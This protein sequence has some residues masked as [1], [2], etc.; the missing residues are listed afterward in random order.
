MLL[1]N[2]N[3]KANVPIAFGW[4]KEE[5]YG[6][7]KN[8]LELI[9][10]NEHGWALCTDFKVVSLLMGLMRGNPKYPCHLCLWDSRWK[11]QYEKKDWPIRTAA[12][13]KIDTFN[14]VADALVPAEKILLPPLHIKLGLV[15]NY[16]KY[17]LRRNADARSFLKTFF[18]NLSNAKLDE[19]KYDLFIRCDEKNKFYLIFIGVLVGPDIRRLVANPDFPLLLDEHELTAFKALKKVIS[20]FL[21]K[22][23]DENYAILVQNMLDAFQ[24]INV[25]MSSKIHYMHCHLD[26]FARQLPTESDEQGERFHQTC[27]PFEANYKGKDV[28]ALITDLC[29][30]L[31]ADV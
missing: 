1:H 21:G 18:P 20:G 28:L 15:K 16:L 12:N 27:K 30:Q 9:K 5:S 6:S 7:I 10:Y 31:A 3:I 14:I 19:G 4:D 24:T 17:M 13:R 2:R 26:A 11:N 25:H 22:N 8:I 29:W 23:R